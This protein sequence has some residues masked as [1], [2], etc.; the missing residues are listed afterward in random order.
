M[1]E[2][3]KKTVMMGIWIA[4]SLM[5]A[6]GGLWALMPELLTA[7]MGIGFMGFTLGVLSHLSALVLG[8]MFFLELIG[9][10]KVRK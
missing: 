5:T 2:K 9:V 4:L 7:P 8:G 1:K 3:D 10:V 6:L